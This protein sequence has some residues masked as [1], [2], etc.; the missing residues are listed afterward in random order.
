M[1]S[2]V[3]IMNDIR[4]IK[5]DKVEVHDGYNPITKDITLSFQ[6]TTKAY[7]NGFTKYMKLSD[8]IVKFKLQKEINSI[9]SKATI[10]SKKYGYKLHINETFT[11][12]GD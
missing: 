4:K 2:F 5:S 1:E 6:I 12:C 3:K 10:I 7:G 8:A 9:I 11:Y